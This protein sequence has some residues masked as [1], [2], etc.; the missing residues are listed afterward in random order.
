MEMKTHILLEGLIEDFLGDQG[1][2]VQ[3][4]PANQ[5]PLFRRDAFL[6]PVGCG[7]RVLKELAA[8]FR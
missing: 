1:L 4:M 5:E 7:W 6:G 8:L 3:T 2:F